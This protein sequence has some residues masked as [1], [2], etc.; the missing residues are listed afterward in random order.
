MK[1]K[2]LFTLLFVA[3][4]ANAQI[5]NIP[6]V[7][8][9]NKLVNAAVA[10]PNAYTAQDANGDYMVVDINSDGEIQE[11][12][13]Q[14]VYRLRLNNSNITDLT[15]IQYFTNLTHL[16]ADNNNNL[17]LLDISNMTNLL[18][19]N[20]QYCGLTSLDVTGCSN[21][22]KLECGVNQLTSLDLSG[23]SSLEFLTCSNNQLT[24]IDF[25]PVNLTYFYASDNP[26]IIV[27]LSAQSNLQGFSLYNCTDLTTVYI[28]NGSVQYFN[29]EEFG[30]CD[31]LDFVCVDDAEYDAAYGS[32]LAAAGWDD[33]MNIED[34]VITT[35]CP[36]TGE[37]GNAITGT[38]RF[39]LDSNGC[40]TS[41]IT[42]SFVKVT[43]IH[44]NNVNTIFTNSNG[45][46]SFAAETGDYNVALDLNEMPYFTSTAAPVINFA[47]LD[48][49]SIVQDLC[50]TP[51]GIHPDLEV[52]AATNWSMAPGF[53]TMFFLIYKNKGN[54]MLDGTISFSF[55]D[56]VLEHVSAIPAYDNLT[57]G[58]LSWD[59]ADLE[60][61]ET[62]QIIVTLHL[63]SPTDTP[64]VN[65]DE[66]FDFTVLGTI[67]QTDDTPEDNE[68]TFSQITTGSF[69]PNNIVCLQGASLSPD[70]I[71][72]YL[73]Y[74]INFENIGTG[75]AQF[76]VVTDEIDA[77]KYDVNSLQV[78]N[79]S[80]AVNASLENNTITF[81]FDD[82]D[83]APDAQGN[84]TFKIKSLNTIAV[85]ESVMNDA[86]IVFDFNEAIETNDAITTFEATAAAQNFT[87]ATV[88]LYPNPA[89]D[90]VT[91]TANS[92][93]KAIAV[94][95]IQGRLLSNVEMN[96]STTSFSLSAN[97]SGVYFAKITTANGTTTEKIIK[98]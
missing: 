88:S 12:E 41:D 13:A 36:I 55:D 46:Y 26:L 94:Y 42:Q 65:I 9:K 68:V 60:P 73:H 98:K 92:A 23:A 3:V 96:S 2:L 10:T 22:E 8:F 91:I 70:E 69:D 79:S 4:M 43:S 52:V 66:E 78:L 59:F 71:G 17:T 16:K 28:K 44:D 51:D 30:Q 89:T 20:V 61:F 58:L 56:A 76:V 34:I 11:S 86:S 32:I 35:T 18:D 38:V 24:S 39:D 81:R 64:P 62:R 45:Y 85:G 74:T 40:D 93:I 57:S 49:T 95:D 15:G 25:S 54:Q 80:H 97:P 48:G 77:T 21:L 83:L 33:D 72:E 19:V 1:Q 67:S 5:V 53:D 37:E 47:A 75:A 7:N 82:I 29:S 31:S 50:I 6:D 87:N 27:D 14:A 84:V 90:V 63:N